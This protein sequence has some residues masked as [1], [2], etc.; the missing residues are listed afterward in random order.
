MT[1]H[2]FYIWV[3]MRVESFTV[4]QAEG[5]EKVHD[6]I[7]EVLPSELEGVEGPFKLS[8]TG[9]WI[10][11]RW[12]GCIKGLDFSTLR[13][14]DSDEEPIFATAPFLENIIQVRYLL[15]H[16]KGDNPLLLPFAIAVEGEV[17]EVEEDEE[18]HQRAKFNSDGTPGSRRENWNKHV[19]GILE[20][21]TEEDWF[22]VGVHYAFEDSEIE[23]EKEP[24]AKG[25]TGA[26]AVIEALAELVERIKADPQLSK[27]WEKVL[28][29]GKEQK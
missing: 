18:W 26:P 3:L 28:A 25:T 9:L 21:H 19:L 24:Q 4:F 16:I 10:G 14:H 12:Q 13:D 17:E 23:M 2:S 7:E 5:Y 15:E 6:W 11:G 20:E 22:A 29:V 8:L 27:E 1:T